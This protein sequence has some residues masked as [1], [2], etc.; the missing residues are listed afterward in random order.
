MFPEADQLLI[1]LIDRLVK[2]S[3]IKRFTAAES[4]AHPYFD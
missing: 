1:D 2:Y 4:L 3:P